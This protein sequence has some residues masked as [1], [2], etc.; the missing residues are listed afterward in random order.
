LMVGIIGMIIA[1]LE[2]NIII[3]GICSLFIRK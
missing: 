1:R 3:T 2:I